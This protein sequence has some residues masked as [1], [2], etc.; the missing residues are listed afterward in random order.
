MA[1]VALPS[2]GSETWPNAGVRRD[3]NAAFEPLDLFTIKSGEAIKD[4][5][6]SFTDRGGAH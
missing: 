2:F 6:Y 4:E 3:R 5:I 1:N